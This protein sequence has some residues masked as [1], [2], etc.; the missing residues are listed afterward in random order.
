MSALG[1]DIAADFLAVEIPER[2]VR[3]IPI[4]QPGPGSDPG[5]VVVPGSSIWLPLSLTGLL[6]T[7][8]TV[9]DR[10]PILSL[11]DGTTTI[12]S[13]RVGAAITASSTVQ[14]VFAAGLGYAHSSVIA[15]VSAAGIPH[16]RAYPGWRIRLAT[17]GLLAG[18][19]WSGLVLQVVDVST[20]HAERELSRQLAQAA[21]LLPEYPGEG[22]RMP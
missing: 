4:A 13:Y 3:V 1:A 18:D 20:G 8:A 22:V 5:P 21:G 10:A 19:Q 16:R 14:V 15:G 11:D 12:E 6:A 2:I 17:S 9:G 7:S